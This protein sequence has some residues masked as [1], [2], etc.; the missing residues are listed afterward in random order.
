MGGKGKRPARVL[1]SIVA[2]GRVA[3]AWLAATR[4]R[5][6]TNKD[7]LHSTPL[8]PFNKLKL[9]LMFVP[10]NWHNNALY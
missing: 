3:T 10:L 2:R 7:R 6:A 4:M 1:A 9:Y 8:T 5:T